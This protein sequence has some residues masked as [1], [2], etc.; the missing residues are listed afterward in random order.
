MMSTDS[1]VNNWLM[2]FV[3]DNSADAPWNAASAN[4]IV[5]IVMVDLWFFVDDMFD[6]VMNC[7]ASALHW[8]MFDSFL[9]FV[10]NWFAV[11]G[12]AGFHLAS[13]MPWFK[14]FNMNFCLKFM[15]AMCDHTFAVLSNNFWLISDYL[16]VMFC[17]AV[18]NMRRN[19]A[20]IL[21]PGWTFVMLD[22]G[23]VVG[24]RT[25]NMDFSVSWGFVYIMV[26]D[27]L[28]N[29]LA[30]GTQVMAHFVIW[31]NVVQ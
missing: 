6:V 20:F 18:Y 2:M 21:M 8:V 13:F 5:N 26:N 15:V 23:F 25:L 12:L 30:M 10:V 14:F 29:C 31:S 9:N 17:V 27:G 4:F 24:S 11:Y 7:A 3:F 16:S 19:M 1:F 22:N 28:N